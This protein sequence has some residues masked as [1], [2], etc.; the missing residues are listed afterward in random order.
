MPK[1]KGY[2]NPKPR[3]VKKVVKPKPKGPVSY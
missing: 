1:L 2:K 3:K